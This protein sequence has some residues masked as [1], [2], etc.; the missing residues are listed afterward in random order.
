MLG[1][2]IGGVVGLVTGKWP[3]VI[4]GVLLGHQFDR[5][6]AKYAA[7]RLPANFVPVAFAVMG[8]LAKSDGRVSED[9]IRLARTA[10]HAMD[11]D[12][13][14]TRDAMNAFN[15]GKSP[16]FDLDA[17]LGRL[18]K[19]ANLETAIG[20]QLIELLL[21]VLL[22]KD[23][24][25]RAERRILWQVC[26]VFSV[27]RV[28]LAQME[29]ASRINRQFSG[30]AGPTTADGPN[31]ANNAF[32]VLGLNADASDKE[33][34]NAYR[35]LTNRYHPDKLVGV[36]DDPAA[37]EAA[38]RKTREIREAYEMLRKRRGFK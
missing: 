38:G 13:D 25:S 19:P 32:A 9:E 17:A 21:P 23:E 33:I 22:I 18:G 36:N 10:M 24:A 20:R 35:R 16:D 11:L 7:R 26:E 14:Q 27:S 12:G 37:L 30:H 2:V 8:H 31:A 1:K 29:A 3:I 34:K 5:G 4:A 6:Y 28:E 15:A